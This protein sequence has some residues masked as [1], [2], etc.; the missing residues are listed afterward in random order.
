MLKD[1]LVALGYLAPRDGAEAR[2]R[3]NRWVAS[4]PLRWRFYSSGLYISPFAPLALGF[5]AGILTVC[6]ASAAASSWCRR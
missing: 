1:S 5:G 4:L 6:S 3:H 2:P